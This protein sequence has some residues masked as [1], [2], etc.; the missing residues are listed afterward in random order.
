M[1]DT[2]QFLQDLTWPT[3]LAVIFGLLAF[4]YWQG[5]E[6]YYSLL[7]SSSIPGPRP[8]PWVGN[9][10]DV[11]KYGGL[12]KMLLNYFYKY[13]HVHKMCIGRTPTIVVTDTEII[14]QIMVKD[15]WKFPNR[16]RFV[17][18]KPPL[19][20]ALFITRD[21]TWKRIRHT[22][23]PI[24]TAAKLKQ[25]VPLIETA[26]EKL[27]TKMQAFAETGMCLNLLCVI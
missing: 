26:S 27:M 22:L 16:P 24:F 11:Y 15:F 21:E 17:R 23:T 7:G 13:G 18:P 2:L 6:R 1:V 20:S 5:V 19:N 10:P 8:W 3:W 25:I 4:I 12:H 9:L 14:K